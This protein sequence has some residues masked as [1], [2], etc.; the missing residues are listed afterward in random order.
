MNFIERFNKITNPITSWKGAGIILFDKDDLSLLLVKDTKSK[1]FGFPK[2]HY[3]EYDKTP[4]ETA[5][6]EL[7]E[8]TGLTIEDIELLNEAPVLCKNKYYF[9]VG[10]INTNIKNPERFYITKEEPTISLVKYFNI[11][12]IFKLNTNISLKKFIILYNK[13]AKCSAAGSLQQ[14][15]K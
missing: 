7:N 11:N 10:R 8:E 13:F 6:R 14:G 15:H 4:F 5:I 2:G 1:K 12:K 9:W 3:E